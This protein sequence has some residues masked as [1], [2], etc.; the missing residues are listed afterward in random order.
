MKMQGFLVVLVV[1]LV[2]EP[3]F[4]LVRLVIL[5]EAGTHLIFD[6]LRR[7]SSVAVTSRHATAVTLAT[8]GKDE[9]FGCFMRYPV[10]VAHSDLNGRFRKD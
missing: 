4:P 6:A 2:H 9:I 1:V 7:K 8:T 3:H 10:P 5:V